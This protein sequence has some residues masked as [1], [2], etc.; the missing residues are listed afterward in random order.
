MLEKRI[1]LIL[2]CEITVD[3]DKLRKA[4]TEL[5]KENE[6]LKRTLYLNNKEIKRQKDE[7]GKMVAKIIRQNKKIESLIKL[8][9]GPTASSAPNQ[10]DE[11][12]KIGFKEDGKQDDF[13]LLM[14]ENLPYTLDFRTNSLRFQ[15]AGCL[16]Y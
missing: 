7:L 12:E 6:G 8:K 3:K 9:K 16:L 10:A 14:Q 2:E 15:Y 13:N 11:F 1:E 5:V 4:I